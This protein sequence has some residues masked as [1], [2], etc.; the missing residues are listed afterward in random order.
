[1][2]EKDIKLFDT[3]I[4]Q[5]KKLMGNIVYERK[6]Y[7]I[8]LNMLLKTLIKIRNS[9]DRKMKDIMIAQSEILDEMYKLFDDLYNNGDEKCREKK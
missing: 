9:H 3:A 8:K 1:M 2:K 6:K 7:H 4:H 5:V